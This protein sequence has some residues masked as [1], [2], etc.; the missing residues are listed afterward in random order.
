MTADFCSVCKREMRFS[1]IQNHTNECEGLASACSCAHRCAVAGPWHHLWEPGR[2]ADNPHGL[3]C[4]SLR[5]FRLATHLPREGWWRRL[6]FLKEHLLPA[7]CS[8]KAIGQVETSQRG[9]TQPADH[10]LDHAELVKI[11]WNQLVQHI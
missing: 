3:L 5:L 4:P 6:H 8:E 10:E 7:S 2:G 11:A 1:C 9:W